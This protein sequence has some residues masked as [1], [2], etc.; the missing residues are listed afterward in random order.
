MMITVGLVGVLLEVR[1]CIPLDAANDGSYDSFAQILPNSNTSSQ[2]ISETR[3]VQFHL[4]GL[5]FSALLYM[6]PS[7]QKVPS[8]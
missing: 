8:I 7:E 4:I 1:A 5:F 3:L 6:I 2:S